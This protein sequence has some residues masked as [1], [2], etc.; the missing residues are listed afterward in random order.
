[1]LEIAWVQEGSTFGVN[2]TGVG[3]ALC[4]RI[5]VAAGGVGVVGLAGVRLLTQTVTTSGLDTL[6]VQALE[7][8]R[9]PWASHH[10]AK[11][12]LGL[13]LAAAAGGDC[14]ADTA[15]LR[16]QE[17][18]VG[19]VASAATVTR[20]VRALAAGIALSGG[21]SGPGASHGAVGGCGPWPAPAP[22]RRESAAATR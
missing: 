20:V 19:A 9:A 13:A 3:G 18:L 6:L 8:C 17:S 21:G 4:P 15:L 2:A 11:V 16:G 5:E 1:M 12:L 14:L 10:P 7:G 22:P